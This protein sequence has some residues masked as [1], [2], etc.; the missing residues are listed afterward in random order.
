MPRPSDCSFT[1]FGPNR[2]D[3]P[4]IAMNLI[5]SVVTA[6]AGAADLPGGTVTSFLRAIT[7][8]T[9]LWADDGP[10][11]GLGTV[12]SALAAIDATLAVA[13][14][15]MVYFRTGYRSMRD[16]VR[17]GLA[18]V[19]VIGALAFVAT[20]MRHAALAYL[21]LDPAKPALELQIRA[22][23]IATPADSVSS[24]A[25]VEPMPTGPNTGFAVR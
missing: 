6:A 15:L 14:L 21:G 1:D 7:D 16:M 8:G 5:F 19:A 17:H 18:A 22:P 20:D 13:I 9:G 24:P 10:D 25:A 12:M 23:G 3:E 11:G 4:D 2:T